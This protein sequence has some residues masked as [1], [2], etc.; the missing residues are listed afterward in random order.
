MPFLGSIAQVAGYTIE[1]VTTSRVTVTVFNIRRDRISEIEI[2]NFDGASGPPAPQPKTIGSNIGRVV[3]L[4]NALNG[5][6]AT[7]KFTSGSQRF[8]FGIT[9]DGQGIFDVT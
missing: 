2:L 4:A 5:E 9:P 8:E 7:V 3:F 1:V 6:T